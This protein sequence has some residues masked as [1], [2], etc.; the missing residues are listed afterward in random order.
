MDN[1]V[2]TV[3]CERMLTGHSCWW[4]CFRELSIDSQQASLKPKCPHSL[5]TGSE[6]CLPTAC[7]LDAACTTLH[8][9]AG[10]V[11]V[12]LQTYSCCHDVMQLGQLVREPGGTQLPGPFDYRY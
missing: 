10:L 1:V 7:P 4:R 12:V 11:P 2:N 3:V 9:T 8:Y 5:L 6:C